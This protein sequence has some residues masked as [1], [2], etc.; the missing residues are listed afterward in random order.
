MDKTLT[1]T[2]SIPTYNSAKYLEGCLA[3][4]AQQDYPKNAVEIIITDAGSHDATLSI[5]KKYTNLIFE[6]KLKLGEYGTQIAAQKAKGD[7]FVVFAADNRLVGN[8][9]LKKVAQVFS[10][11]ENL[12]CLWGKMIA[13]RNDPAIMHYYELIQSEPLARFIN[14]NL[15]FYLNNTQNKNLA[16]IRYKVFNVDPRKPLCWGANG[17]VYKFKDVRE[18]FPGKD[19]VGD[20]EIFQYMVERGNNLVAYSFDLNIYHHTV[21]SVWHWVRK[22]RRNYA[23]IFLATRQARRIDWFYFGNFKLKMSLWLV[24]SLVPVFSLLHSIYLVLKDKN[25]Y[26]LYH[27]LMSFL[28]T[29]T[30]IFWTLVLPEGRKTLIEHLFYKDAIRKYV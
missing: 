11:Y 17:I 30:Y 2:F 28:Q 16:G 14:R 26:W 25:L 18:L 13:S 4:I 9:W 24:Y 8:D 15:D 10:H 20:N 12:S 23:E 29:V 3:S 5:A 1:F 27:P 22:W 6:N 7:L 21:D 19:Y